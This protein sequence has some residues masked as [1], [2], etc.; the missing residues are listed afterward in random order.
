GSPGTSAVTVTAT[1]LSLSHSVTFTFILQ[2]FALS[3]SPADI[4]VNSGTAGSSTLTTTSVNGFAGTV[5]LS[6][7]VSPSTGLTCTISPSNVPL[8]TSG[9]ATLSCNGSAG[10]YAVTVAGNSGSLSHVSTV[11]Y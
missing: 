1:C 7:T 8:G 10:S 2:D 9:S 11:T 6:A 3:A 4:T 5:A